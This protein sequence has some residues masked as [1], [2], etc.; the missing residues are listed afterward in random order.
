MKLNPSEYIFAIKGGTFL[1][2]LV[3]SKGIEPNLE[4][5]QAILDMMPPQNMNEVQ[6]FIGR[7]TALNKFIARFEQHAMLVKSMTFEQHL[8]DLE[9]VFV[10]LSQYR[11][12]LNL[13]KYV[14]AIKK[15]NFLSFLVSSKEIDPNPEKI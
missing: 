6:R 11:M 9:E 8:L 15:G 12:K 14:F 13:S 10:V 1:G 3:S 4:K 7:L 2:F 5:I